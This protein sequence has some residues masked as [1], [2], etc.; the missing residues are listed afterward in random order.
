MVLTKSQKTA[1]DN[2]AVQFRMNCPN[3]RHFSTQET[4]FRHADPEAIFLYGV[5]CSLP[6]NANRKRAEIAETIA[7]LLNRQTTTAK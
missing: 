2:I 3:L 6:K 1:L 4:L 5:W 7:S